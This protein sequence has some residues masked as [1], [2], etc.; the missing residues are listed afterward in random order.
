MGSVVEASDRQYC[1]VAKLYASQVVKGELKACSWVRLACQRQLT[2]LEEQ[3]EY[4]YDEVRAARVCKF[5]E[6]LPHIKG[7]WKTA[8]VTL[9]PWQCFILTTLFGW[10]DKNGHRRFRTALIVVPR[11][12]GKTL[13]AAGIALYML[14]AD[15]E[16][17]AEVYS[18]AVTKDQARL[19]WETAQLMVKRE[20]EMR[21]VFGVEPLSHSIT[22]E[23]TGSYFKPLARD[24]DSLEG[25][26]PHCV[27]IDELHAH[28]TREVWD[29]L[30]IARGSRRQSLM[31]AITTA[32]DNKTGVCYEQLNYVEQILAGRH[33]DDRYFG[34]NYTVDVGDDWTS[35]ESARKANPN[36]GVSVLQ[37]DM[38]TMC[39]QAQ[40]NAESQN[41]YL[42]KRLNIWV[43]VGTAYFNML[44]WEQRCKDESLRPEQFTGAICMAAIDLASKSDLTAKLLVFEKAGHFYVFGKYYLPDAA[45][46]S[47]M[48]NADFY[49][50]WSLDD[51]LTI[52]DGDIT[53][54]EF[55]ERDVVADMS[56]FGPER[57]G[58]DPNYNAGQFCTRMKDEGVPIEQVAHSVL[59][60]SE[61]MK[62]LQA[63]IMAGRIHHNGDPVLAW[64]MSNVMAK[65]DAK[66]NVYPR[67][68]RATEKIDPAVALI[69]AMNLHSRRD[70]NGYSYSGLKSVG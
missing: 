56:R 17:G 37:D 29:V 13:L 54:Y 58:V 65:V 3:E 41:A 44:A 20:P 19:S 34:I 12:N 63:L 57:V 26:G 46:D 16:P 9:E 31:F 38:E 62:E 60:F 39:R 21:T 70:D 61:P 14:C 23:V 47:G 32:G 22:V 11:K 43:S 55:V 45:L 59:N 52:T 66:G 4:T 24:A 10:I 40:A 68:A 53:D 69:A 6:N 1:A 36:Y 7:T 15:G 48:P 49:R 30:N 8:N 27:I 28:K 64:A 51:L 33:K 67:K 25:L 50:G 35:I 2:D 42:T 18:A 5:I